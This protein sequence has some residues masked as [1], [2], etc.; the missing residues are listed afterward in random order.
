MNKKYY[1]AYIVLGVLLAA[2]VA[3]SAVMISASRKSGD[4]LDE[5]RSE[6]DRLGETI[7]SLE[8]GK[9]ELELTRSQLEG[10][11]ATLKSKLAALEQQMSDAGSSYQSELDAVRAELEAKNAEITA[12]EADIAKF[13]TVYSIDIRA[14]AQLLDEL[15][16][17]ITTACPYVRMVDEIILDE[18]G[19]ETG[20]V[21]YKWVLVADL[22]EEAK[23]AAEA[24]GEEYIEGQQILREDVFYPQISVY[25]EDLA[26]GYHFGYN[27]DYVYDPASVIKAPVIAA[28]LEQ[29]AKDEQNYLDSLEARGELPELYDSDGDGVNDAKKIVRSNPNYDLSQTVKYDKATMFKPG[30]G[31]IQDMPDGTELSYYDFVKYALEY[32]DNVAYNQIKNRFGYTAFYSFAAKAGAKTASK[33][34]NKMTA[35]DAG[36]LFKSIWKF[37]DSDD[38]YGEILRASMQKANHTVIIPFGAAGSTVLHKYGWDTDAYHDAGIVLSGEKPYVLAVFSDLDKG[39]DEINEYLREIVKKIDRLHKNFYK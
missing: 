37:I 35:Y 6:G 29:I 33:N 23:L 4:E 31:K 28:I 1:I 10:E 5:L 7:D 14:Q 3:V 11:V 34:A 36:K 21:T 15:I 27:E 25:Y 20:E 2:A 18:D 8:A 32:S 17:Y 13:T 16:E 24:A 38:N 30:S 12:L 19:N 26:T 9:A 39:G 22:E